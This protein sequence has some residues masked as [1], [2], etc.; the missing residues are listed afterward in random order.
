MQVDTRPTEQETRRLIVFVLYLIGGFLIF[1]FGSNYSEMF[2]T[3]KNA[4]Y[5]WGLTLGLLGLVLLLHRVPRLHP[6]WKPA[7][8]LFAASFANAALLSFGHVLDTYL[9]SSMTDAQ[10]MAL[11][12]LEQALPIVLSIV[13]L[14]K[15]TGDDLGAIFLKRG[16]LRQGLT[17]G[18]ISFGVFAAIFAIIVLLQAD[19]PATTGLTA[20]GVKLSTIVAAIPWILVFI[21]A[22]SLMEELWFRGVSLRKLTPVLEPRVSVIVTALVFASIHVGASYINPTERIIFPTIVF[23]FGLI[24]GYVMLKTNSI[25][26]SVLFHAGYDLLVIL[27]I[28]VSM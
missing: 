9:P 3:N 11:D 17:F 2:P 25:W 1:L 5:E 4:A 10:A 20:T 24:N 13:L 21:F 22:N 14:T 16:N 12:K 15:L 6:Y 8:A 23:V 26:G 28:L 19:A 7:F 18:L 27:P